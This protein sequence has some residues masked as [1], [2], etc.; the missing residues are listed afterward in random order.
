[1]KLKLLIRSYKS[2]SLFSYIFYHIFE[3]IFH[4]TQTMCTSPRVSWVFLPHCLYTHCFSFL[5]RTSFVRLANANFQDTLIFLFLLKMQFFFF[6][7]SFLISTCSEVYTH[8]NTNINDSFCGSLLVTIGFVYS[9]VSSSRPLSGKEHVLLDFE[10]SV[11]SL[12]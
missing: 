2:S 5:E 11:G 12:A 9:S 4:V 7:F 8:T 1:M 6:F 3:T 10:S